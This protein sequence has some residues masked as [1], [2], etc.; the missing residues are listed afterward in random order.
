MEVDCMLT[1]HRSARRRRRRNRRS[2]RLAVPL[3]IPMALGLTLGVILAVNSGTHSTVIE[4]S[5]TGVTDTPIASG[6]SA[7]T[8]PAAAHTPRAA[9]AA[10]V[11]CDLIVPANP[12]SARGLATPY[13]LTGPNGM[14]PRQSGCTMANAANLGAFVQATIL[15]RATGKLSV[16]EPLVITGGTTPVARPVMPALPRGA[17]VNIMFG[18]NGA[19]LHLLNANGTN[20][21]RQGN[22]VSGLPGSD[23]GQV[24]YC[25][26]VSFYNAANRARGAGTLTIPAL[27]TTGAGQPCPTTRSFALIDQDQSDNVTTQY[28]VNGNGQTAQDNTANAANLAG[29][30]V[31]SNGS[32]NALLNGFIDPAVGCTPFTAPDLSNGGAAGTSQSLDE[33]MAAK[34]QQ[35]PIAL[36]PLTDPMTMLNA[37]QSTTK[38]NL[39]RRGVDQ[40]PVSAAQTDDTPAMYCANMLNVQTKFINALRANLINKT[41]PVPAAG[42]NLFTFMA[43]R[44]SASFTNLGCANFGLKNTVNLTLQNNVAVGAALNVM[45]QAPANP[46]GTAMAAPAASASA[47]PAASAS[48]AP[49][50]SASAA[51]AASASAAPAASASAAPAA[52]ASAA[53]AA[54]ASAAP[55]A[56]ASAMPAASAS[57]APAASASAMPAASASAAPATAAGTGTTAPQQNPGQSRRHERSAPQRDF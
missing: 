44:L 51:P 11:N 27:G 26:S 56:S 53:P 42:N 23:F 29:A 24:A 30:A 40:A 28:L 35:A 43:A 13:Q 37:A 21:L 33:L 47:A 16:Y 3:A 15:D 52:S 8:G 5:A 19:D 36:T 12:L 32:D 17:V 10:N 2:A 57:A 41:S 20:S 54:S 38:T 1:G 34:D 49:A 55:A 9:A 50:A 45:T 18:F 7:A 48:A 25:N 6:A 22:C 46:N 4:Q 31:I 14:T 39:Y